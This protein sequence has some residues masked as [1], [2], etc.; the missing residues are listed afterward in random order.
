MM[1]ILANTIW[2]FNE[3]YGVKT[4]YKEMIEKCGENTGNA[5]FH[6]AILQQIKFEKEI[7]SYTDLETAKESAVYVLPAAN[8]INRDGSVL[9]RLFGNLGHS[10]IRVLVLGL[11]IQMELGESI[12]DFI[13][14]L[15]KET[16]SALKIMSEHSVSIGIRGE[17]TGAVLDYLGIHNWQVIGCPSYYEPYRQNIMIRNGKNV[18]HDK[19]LYNIKPNLKMTDKII[20]FAVKAGSHIVIQDKDDMKVC[21]QTGY[22]NTLGEG[23]IH[24][25]DNR[26]EWE[27]FFLNEDVSF[28]T[29]LRFHGN[30]MAF[31][32][33]IPALWIVSDERTREMAEAMKLPYVYHH[34]LDN[35]T[36]PD[37]FMELVDYSEKFMENYKQMGE[38][39][40][41][42]LDK[43]GVEHV[44]GRNST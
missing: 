34:Q 26:K 12:R 43:N 8:W 38:A 21:E 10:H 3:R 7:M 5:V 16:I 9:R 33:G 31:S 4:G 27:R 15:A 11:G 44:F 36:N 39:Y 22:M 30:M 28:S 40:V 25:F 20:D 35:V 13:N 42:F 19:I 24:V 41:K 32:C 2:P 6:D 29:G 37:V 23:Y 17:T 1:A 18:S 14:S